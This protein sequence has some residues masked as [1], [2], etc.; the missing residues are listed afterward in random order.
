MNEENIPDDPPPYVKK[1]YTTFVVERHVDAD[2]ETTWN[3]LLEL[4]VKNVL[5]DE[6]PYGK[7]HRPRARQSKSDYKKNKSHHYSRK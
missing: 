1:E 2:R 4:I 6:G 3:V 5:V 7:R